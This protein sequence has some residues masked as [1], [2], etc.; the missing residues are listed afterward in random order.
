MASTN[1]VVKN[2]K[3][4][5]L[6]RFEA[7]GN[8]DLTAQLSRVAFTAQVGSLVNAY[9]YALWVDTNNDTFVDTVVQGGVTSQN[10][11]LIF[12]RLTN[13]GY[14]IPRNLSVNFE[15]HAD[16]APSIASNSL[17]LAF[18]SGNAA[19]GASLV[20]PPMSIAGVKTNGVCASSICEIVLSTVDSTYFTIVNQG[21]LYVTKDTTPVRSRQV[22]GGTPSENLL[23]LNFRAE[24]ENIY[25]LQVQITNTFGDNRSIDRLELYRAGFVEPV[26][27][28]TLGGC[29]SYVVPVGTYCVNIA[30]RNLFIQEGTDVKIMVRARMK[31]DIAGAISGEPLQLS[32]SDRAGPFFVTGEGAVQALGQ[33]SFNNIAANDGDALG[34]GEVFIGAN[35]PAPNQQ[36]TGPAHVS[37]LAQITSISNA[38]PDANGTNVPTG[39]S[40]I[41]QFK[42]STAPNINSYN[43]M[44]NV[45]INRI[46]FN[47]DATNVAL[48]ATKFFLYNK[49]N[50]AIKAPCTP[51]VSNNGF[52]TGHILVFCTQRGDVNTTIQRGLDQTL[53]LQA[54]ILNAKMNPASPSTLL[55]SL[56]NFASKDMAY[57]DTNNSHFEW[58]DTDAAASTFFYWVDYPE[59][60]VR[61]TLYQS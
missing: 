27:Y 20:Y 36:I 16:I 52:A 59:T 13:G 37:V 28:G 42:I 32:L 57:F 4:V 44:N 1:V 43:G 54:S 21:N 25:I 34:E 29:G 5:S 61:S 51:L 48:D 53:V 58:I 10:G 22:L 26:G 12:D 38:N 2:Q 9:N 6:L 39:V 15:V 30:F 55:V 49:A 8:R 47:V 17:Q 14:I 40:D 24:Y 18:A 50:S 7:S 3:N 31:D 23:L 60:T 35:T 33:D 45:I 41:G 19:V 11:V 46:I 56:Q